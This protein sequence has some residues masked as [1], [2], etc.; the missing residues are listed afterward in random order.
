MTKITVIASSIALTLVA[1]PLA[2]AECVL[3]MSMDNPGQGRKDVTC[4]RVARNSN[5]GNFR[6]WRCCP[7]D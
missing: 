2:A 7:N 5:N 6:Y 3:L 1:S 4:R